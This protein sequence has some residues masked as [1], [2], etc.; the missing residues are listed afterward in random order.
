MLPE[1]FARWFAARGWTLRPHQRQVL[2]STGDVLLLAPTGAG[3]T[4]A[5]FLSS[6]VALAADPRPRLHTL[7]VSPLKALA[8]DIQRNLMRPI[9]EMGLAITVETRTGDTTQERRRRQREAPPH[10]LLTTPESLALLVSLPDWR[11]TLAG[12]RSACGLFARRHEVCG[13]P[14]RSDGRLLERWN[15]GD[16]H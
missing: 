11:A 15:R 2:E 12:V 13:P 10:C 9:E 4:L 7:Y 3:K 1:P 5:G 16:L 14:P 6:L 8:A